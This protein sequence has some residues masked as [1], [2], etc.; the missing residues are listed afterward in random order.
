VSAKLNAGIETASCILGTCTTSSLCLVCLTTL[1]ARL[2]LQ[3]WYLVRRWLYAA[4]AASTCFLQTKQSL[5][6][7]SCRPRHRTHLY[8]PVSSLP[9]HSFI[10]WPG[11]HD[12]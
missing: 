5:D 3:V 10:A 12:I 7:D 9:I 2:V 1:R 8:N 6:H 11:C 4:C